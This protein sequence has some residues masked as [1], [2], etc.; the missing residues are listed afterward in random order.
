M[1]S[2][3]IAAF[4]DGSIGGNPAGVVISEVLP[5]AEEMQRIA[6]EVGYSETAFAAPEGGRW[7]TRYFAPLIEV[8]FCG[9]ATIALGAGLALRQG[10]GVFKLRLNNADIT[11]E[12]KR[13][14]ERLVAALQ[15]PPTRSTAASAADVMEALELFGLPEADL[16][17]HLTAAIH[18]GGAGGIIW[19]SKFLS[20]EPH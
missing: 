18:A 10:D 3:R 1:N 15:S 4:A 11:V 14:G 20:P 2:L 17:R 9:H 16:D 6:A 19:F 12:G 13:D 7:R 5:A 8:P